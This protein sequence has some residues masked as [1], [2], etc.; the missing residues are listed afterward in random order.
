[1]V[2]V[3][4]RKKLVCYVVAVKDA[5]GER[6][7]ALNEDREWLANLGAESAAL[8]ERAGVYCCNPSPELRR[9]AAA[10]L[11]V[12]AGA[13]L[14]VHRLFQDSDSDECAEVIARKVGL[15]H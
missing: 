10:A 3:I 8:A 1:M 9:A 11:G 5:A 12:D 14:V 15:V 7:C 2:M 6:C 13:E 4:D